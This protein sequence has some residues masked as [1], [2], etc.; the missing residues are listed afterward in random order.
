RF[1]LLAR[2]VPIAC[3]PRNLGFLAGRGGTMTRRGRIARPRRLHLGASP[4]IRF[5]ACSGAPSHG[6]SKAQDHADFQVGLQQGFVTDGMGFRVK[7]HGIN[8]E[9]LPEVG[10]KA[11]LERI[12]CANEND[13][14]GLGRLLQY[15]NSWIAPD[16][17]YIWSE[18]D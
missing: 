9:P 7:L 16:D 6:S 14:D 10:N 3:E 15:R 8:F 12:R 13:R 2:V 5:A 18:R 17:D 11:T 1:L 4:F